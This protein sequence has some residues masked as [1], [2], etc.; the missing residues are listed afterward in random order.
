MA[1]H[2]A[3][4]LCAADDAD[5]LA[6]LARSCAGRED[7]TH[8]DVVAPLTRAL[9]RLV[10][11]DASGCADALAELEPRLWRVG[12]SD[13]QRE[14]VEETRLCALVRAG[15]C[16]EALA[17]VDRRLDRRRCRRDEWFQAQAQVTE[18]WPPETD[19]FFDASGA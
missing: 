10:R 5:G 12:G 15:R 19:T 13:A 7:R 6:T 8:V 14:V 16:A 2:A 4:V 9:L 3:V 11:G 17:L 1:M 18:I